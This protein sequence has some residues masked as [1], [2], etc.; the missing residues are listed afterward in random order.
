MP[1]QLNIENIVSILAGVMLLS[2]IL[3][4]IITLIY[5]LKVVR[6]LDKI[7]LAHGIDKDQFDLFYRRFN[8]YKKAVFNPKF[9]TEKRKHYIFDPK[10]LEG[11]IKFID[12]KIMKT[13]TFFYRLSLFFVALVALT[14]WLN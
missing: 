1:F 8:Y 3:Y 11:K 12:K 13:H 9:F 4:Y 14:S 2:I 5:Y 10:I 6:K 7:I